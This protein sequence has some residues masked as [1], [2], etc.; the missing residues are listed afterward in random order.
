M[1]SN[2]SSEREAIDLVVARA[3]TDPGFRSQLL[4]E[5]HRA[6]HDAF[7]IRIPEDFRIRFIERDTD[8]DAL[9]VL[10]DL[11]PPQPL[12]DELSEHDLESVT[13]GTHAHNAHLAWKGT[14]A[15]KASG[16]HSS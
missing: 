5:P 13:G 4:A 11:R 8:V 12:A 3:E 14:V 9:I 2:S 15:P 7:G 6:I 10:P 1:P 16:P